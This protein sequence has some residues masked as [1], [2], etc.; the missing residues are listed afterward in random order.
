MMR[1]ESVEDDSDKSV[2][3]RSGWPDNLDVT[4]AVDPVQSSSAMSEKVT[5]C[6]LRPQLRFGL[7]DRP[8]VLLVRTWI[9]IGCTEG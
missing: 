7:S 2:E 3:I 1:R 9:V 8:R 4:L 5:H 6:A